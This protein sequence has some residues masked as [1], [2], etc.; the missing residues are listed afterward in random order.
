MYIYWKM[1]Y[2]L[3]SAAVQVERDSKS[4][5]DEILLQYYYY[6]CTRVVGYRKQSVN[7]LNYAM[8]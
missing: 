3:I 4:K 5:E 6:H 2:G 7:S 1:S 8:H